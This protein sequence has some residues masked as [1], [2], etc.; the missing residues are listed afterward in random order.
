[1]LRRIYVV[2]DPEVKAEIIR[3]VADDA[4]NGDTDYAIY[5]DGDEAY[6]ALDYGDLR[7]LIAMPIGSGARDREPYVVIERDEWP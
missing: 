5:I 1:M 3:T 6:V 7:I 4:E 2:R